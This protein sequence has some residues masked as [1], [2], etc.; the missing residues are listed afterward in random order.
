MG[1]TSASPGGVSGSLTARKLS[2]G[3]NF[4]TSA[5]GNTI[6]DKLSPVAQG[7]F[8]YNI[9]SQTFVTGG[10]NGG[11][12]D[13]LNGLCVVSSSASA[14][15]KGSIALRRGLNYRAGQ[16]ALFRSTC[17]YDAEFEYYEIKSFS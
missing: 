8:V 17:A 6:V 12:V 13:Q 10:F 3:L 11:T 15:G 5:F 7:H 4:E 14:N 1:Y 9:N 2:S 16:G